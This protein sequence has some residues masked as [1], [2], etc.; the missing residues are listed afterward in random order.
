MSALHS[1]IT[2]KKKTFSLKR[3]SKISIMKK[4]KKQRKKE[5]SLLEEITNLKLVRI[6][7]INKN[8]P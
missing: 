4:V 8:N 7:I 5:F 2:F 1:K 6:I 3:I